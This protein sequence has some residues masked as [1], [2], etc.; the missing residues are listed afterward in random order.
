M[1]S[2]MVHFLKMLRA[3]SGTNWFVFYLNVEPHFMVDYRLLCKWNSHH[4]C[5]NDF[6]SFF[7]QDTF[8]LDRYFGCDIWS[9][10]TFFCRR[11]IKILIVFC[12]WRINL[13]F[14]FQN[15][16][17]YS[18]YKMNKIE[19]FQIYVIFRKNSSSYDLPRVDLYM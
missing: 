7:F 9:M 11:Q 2:K 4:Q 15:C 10:V 13:F 1:K 6:D 8:S 16:I 3:L 12:R 5:Q 17:L 14:F 18:V 19:A